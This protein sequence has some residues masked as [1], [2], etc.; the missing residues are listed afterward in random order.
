LGW[1]LHHK[2]EEVNYDGEEG[3]YVLSNGI[4]LE[5]LR[6]NEFDRAVELKKYYKDDKPIFRITKTNRNKL[7]KQ[8]EDEVTPLKDVLK[9]YQE[10]FDKEETDLVECFN[11]QDWLNQQNAEFLLKL[12]IQDEDFKQAKDKI[13]KWKKFKKYDQLQKLQTNG[14]FSSAEVKADEIYTVYDK[15]PIVK[16]MEKAYSGEPEIIK[17]T[18][19]YVNQTQTQLQI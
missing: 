17:F 4:D 16:W 8:L 11:A 18:E 3:Y 13:I 19:D 9:E 10:K 5:D 14:V 1:K 7:L 6:L 2:W 15:Y 12:D